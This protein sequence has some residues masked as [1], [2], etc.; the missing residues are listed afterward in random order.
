MITEANREQLVN[1][2]ILQTAEVL[3]FIAHGV[4]VYVKAMEDNKFSIKEKGF[5]AI[6]LYPDLVSAI[7]DAKLIGKEVS[8]A[9][10]SP[11]KLTI[12]ANLIYPA[13]AEVSG[14]KAQKLIMDGLGI[15]INISNMIN[16]IQ[17]PSEHFE[18]PPKAILL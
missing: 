2:D 16:T 13:I 18:N 14:K 3:I 1:L 15:I 11:T 8:L 4:D 12:L 9:Y 6:E 17:I 5:G 7:K 10:N